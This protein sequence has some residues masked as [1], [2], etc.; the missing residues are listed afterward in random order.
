MSLVHLRRAVLLRASGGG[1]LRRG[2]A[3]AATA[4]FRAANTHGGAQ[5]HPARLRVAQHDIQELLL[6]DA[7]IDPGLGRGGIAMAFMGFG[8]Y[9]LNGQYFTKT[10]FDTVVLV[11]IVDWRPRPQFSWERAAASC[12][13]APPCWL[14]TCRVSSST[15][16]AAD[17]RQV[18]HVGRPGLLQPRPTVPAVH[19]LEREFRDHDRAFPRDSERGR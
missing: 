16:Y 9:A 3:G 14:P 11:F 2:G 5:L 8:A 1:L 10:V 6:L 4:C 7:H 15:S 13:T 18:L 17:Y 19:H 12:A